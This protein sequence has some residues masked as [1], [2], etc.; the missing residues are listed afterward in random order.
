MPILLMFGVIYF[1]LL[2]PQMKKQKEH[3]ALLNALQKGD[4][5]I[6]RGGVVGKVTGIVGTEVIL[7][8]QER[9]RVRVVRSYIEGK[10][11]S[12]A[13]PAAVVEDKAA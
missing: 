7:E 5:V 10:Y 6:T 9:V 3:Q 13:A 12:P 2:R 11:V 1:I 4:V 8:L